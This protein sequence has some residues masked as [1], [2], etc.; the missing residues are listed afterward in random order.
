MSRRSSASVFGGRA[1]SS[2]VR[3]VSRSCENRRAVALTLAVPTDA[4]AR[5]KSQAN[6]DECCNLS[7]LAYPFTIPSRRAPW[8]SAS[9]SISST[10]DR[11]PWA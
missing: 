11:Q 2:G 7:P 3:S 10:R 9:A 6:R 4:A 5:A 8:L 1:A